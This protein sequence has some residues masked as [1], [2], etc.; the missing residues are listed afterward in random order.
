MQAWYLSGQLRRCYGQLQ[1][2]ISSNTSLLLKIR[3]GQAGQGLQLSTIL[4]FCFVTSSQVK[5]N[6]S[7]QRGQNRNINSLVMRLKFYA[8]AGPVGGFVTLGN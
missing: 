4:M 1:L 6:K 7:H 3:L 2:T 8:G 5:V